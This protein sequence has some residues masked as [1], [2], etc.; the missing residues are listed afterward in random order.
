MEKRGHRG[1]I[2]DMMKSYLSDR[3][4][5]V[6]MNGKV[7]NKNRITTG[8]PQGSILGLFLFLPYIN[9]LDSSSGN[10]KVSMFADDTTINNAKKM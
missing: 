8:F 7:T 3:W 6:D 2:H 5:Y 9:N 1:P 4:Q 10:S